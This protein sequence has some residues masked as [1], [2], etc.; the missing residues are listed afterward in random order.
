MKNEQ[1]FLDIKEKY[2]VDL[3]QCELI[4]KIEECTGRM[5]EFELL[6]QIVK[7]LK[8]RVQKHKEYIIYTSRF[9]GGVILVYR[10]KCKLGDESAPAGKDKKRRL[11]LPLRGRRRELRKTESAGMCSGLVTRKLNRTRLLKRKR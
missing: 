10:L 4:L 7:V 6:R 11:G 9:K 2:G 3:N 1:V 8:R 5:M